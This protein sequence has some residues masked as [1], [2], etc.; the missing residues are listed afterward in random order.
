[1]KSLFQTRLAMANKAKQGQ[2]ETSNSILFLLMR[3]S[4]EAKTSVQA[5][6]FTPRRSMLERLPQ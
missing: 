1:M 2:I 3:T 4:F 6:L 5:D